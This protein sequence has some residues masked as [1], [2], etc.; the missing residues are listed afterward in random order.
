MRGKTV[1]V[2]GF[3][4]DAFIVGRAYRIKIESG[5][6]IINALDCDFY[7]DIEHGGFADQGLTKSKLIDV[8]EK[9]VDAIFVGFNENRTIA[10][11]NTYAFEAIRHKNC[12]AASPDS[13]KITADR[14]ANG[15]NMSDTFSIYIDELGVKE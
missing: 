9:G 12:R 13:L 14:Y 5:Y 15:D 10:Y 8:M 11:F 6:D 7:D 2:T 4:S 3:T 1:K